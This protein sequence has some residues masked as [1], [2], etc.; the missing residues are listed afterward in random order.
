M[1][2]DI[3]SKISLYGDQNS[4]LASIMM[5]RQF[6]VSKTLVQISDNYIGEVLKIM[7]HKT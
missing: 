2:T 5:T 1:L 3:L 7:V 4:R 6:S